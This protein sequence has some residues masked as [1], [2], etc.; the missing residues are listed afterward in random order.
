MT[1]K[2]GDIV[3]VISVRRNVLAEVGNIG[4]VIS[5]ENQ[6]LFSM[7]AMVTVTPTWLAF[8]SIDKEPIT[9]FW[10]HLDELEKIDLQYLTALEKAIYGL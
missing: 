3:R 4:I 9:K 10:F 5:I 2:T 1:F 6:N 7:G 8:D